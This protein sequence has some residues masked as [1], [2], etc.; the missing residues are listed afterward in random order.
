MESQHQSER[1]TCR[2][3]VLGHEATEIL[4]KTSGAGFVLPSVEIP[5]WERLAE[6]LTAALKRDWTCDAVCLFT[7]THSSHGGDSQDRHYE[8]LE[9]WN[10]CGRSAEALWFPLN[11]LA[12]NGF[13]DAEEFRVI[14]QCL[15]ELDFHKRDLSSP[16]ARPGWFVELRDWAA[17][18]MRPLG[19][20]FTGRF[21]QYNASPTFSLIRFETTGPAVWFKAVGEP[22]LREF[23]ITQ[24]LADLF[25][26]FTSKILASKPEWNGWLSGEVDGKNLGE[27][28]DIALWERAAADLARLQIESIV[29]S[30]SIARLAAHD[31]RLDVLLSG[32]DPFFELVGRLMDEQPKTPPAI[33]SREK[34]SLLRVQIDD[35]LTLLSDFGTPNA[36]GHLDLNPWNII[37]SDEG[38]VFLD[39]AEAYV[40][41]PFFSLEY[42]VEH[43][44]R[45]LD[46]SGDWGPRIIDAYKTPWRQKLTGDHMSEALALTPLAAVF[47]YAVGTDT[48]RDESKLRDPK[49]SGY[50]RSLAR[51][52]NREAIS[53]IERRSPCL[54]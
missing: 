1:E 53:L 54:G 26:R 31:L 29:E 25:P 10:A 40:G 38:C 46:G 32:I 18:R 45:G 30:E 51:R 41:Y 17:D 4:L 6:N 8:V 7:P 22:N 3:V 12:S 24:R 13:A 37:V 11:S 20:E 43:L 44:R 2:A 23:P 27:T 28:G 47:A 52:M 21:H 35:A 15:Q 36:L 34:L 42:L 50:F 5:R 49:V 33:L 16:F 9:C 14:E 48:W 19:L 39:W